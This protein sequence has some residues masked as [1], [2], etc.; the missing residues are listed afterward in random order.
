MMHSDRDEGCDGY[1]SI[2]VDFAVRFLKLCYFV[3][4]LQF[5]VVCEGV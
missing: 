2:V 1:R 3:H 4:L 5:L